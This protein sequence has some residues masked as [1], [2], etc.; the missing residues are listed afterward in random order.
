MYY[1]IKS[2]AH[3]QYEEAIKDWRVAE[4]VECLPS[5]LEW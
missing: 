5:K 4:V 2:E 3:L 1:R